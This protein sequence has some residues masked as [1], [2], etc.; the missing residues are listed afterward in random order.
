MKEI[1]G[2]PQAIEEMGY[3]AMTEVQA[4]T[5]PRLLEGKDMLV[6][7][8]TGSG[9]T[10]AFLVPS[11]ELMR[12]V[13]FKPVNGT[14]VIVI[15]PVRE[16]AMQIY[17]VA[18]SLMKGHSQTHGACLASHTSPGSF[19]TCPAAHVSFRVYYLLDV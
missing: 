2:V 11:V 12:A 16:L 8:K 13:R 10:L 19:R 9:K 5:I 3:S 18:R 1:C 15:S 4:R 17:E 7:A 6:A 14:G